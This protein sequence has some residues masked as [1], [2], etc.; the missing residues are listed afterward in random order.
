MPVLEILCLGA[1]PPRVLPHVLPRVLCMHHVPSS[2]R[3]RISPN[4][5]PHYR[6]LTSSGGPHALTLSSN[7]SD[8]RMVLTLTA[9]HAFQ[10]LTVAQYHAP[11]LGP[12]RYPTCA[13]IV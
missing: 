6:P 3:I 4:P 2:P 1:L 13:S 7:I 10:T 9:W 12:F 11:Y 8:G 5:S